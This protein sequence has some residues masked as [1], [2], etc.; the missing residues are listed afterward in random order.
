[1]NKVHKIVMKKRINVHKIYHK[2]YH[3]SI[4]ITYYMRV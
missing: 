2:Y 1:M 4:N 3:P